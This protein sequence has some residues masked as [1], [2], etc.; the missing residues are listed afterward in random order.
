MSLNV[1]TEWVGRNVYG[2]LNN[3]GVKIIMDSQRM[4]L[5]VVTLQG[6][7]ARMLDLRLRTSDDSQK[8]VAT[9]TPSCDKGY[10]MLVLVVPG[11]VDLVRDCVCSRQ[12]DK[13]S[14]H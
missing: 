11:E 12:D 6:L 10:K 3:R 5:K 14:S 1:A 4:K 13:A 8:T 2:R 9:L 7:V